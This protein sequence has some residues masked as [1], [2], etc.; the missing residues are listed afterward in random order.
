MRLPVDTNQLNESDH[1]T[2]AHLTDNEHVHRIAL[3]TEE[4]LIEKGEMAPTLKVKPAVIEQKYGRLIDQLYRFVS[5]PVT[6]VSWCLIRLLRPQKFFQHPVITSLTHRQREFVSIETND[7]AAPTALNHSRRSE[8]LFRQS[9]F[10]QDCHRYSFGTQASC[11]HLLTR[12]ARRDVSR[13]SCLFPVLLHEDQAHQP[14]RH[15]PRP[16][17]DISLDH[18]ATIVI[19]TESDYRDD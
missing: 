11:L 12:G 5:L 16:A 14:R 13:L 17:V 6:G 4:L 9:I 15:R 3:S 19:E 2:A 18:Y 8:F 7:L 10:N 1:S